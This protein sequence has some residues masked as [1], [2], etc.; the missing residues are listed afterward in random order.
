[1]HKAVV[2]WNSGIAA[3]DDDAARA[4]HYMKLTDVDQTTGV[5][6]LVGD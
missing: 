3:N 1:M 5:Q 4:P 2:P 6:V